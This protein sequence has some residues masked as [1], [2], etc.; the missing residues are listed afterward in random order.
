[1]KKEVVIEEAMTVLNAV[2]TPLVL[3]NLTE[4]GRSLIEQLIDDPVFGGV[5]KVLK[6]ML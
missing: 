2:R 5:F 1:M 4:H 3:R 6:R